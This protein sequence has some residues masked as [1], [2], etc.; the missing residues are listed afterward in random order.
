MAT[1][2]YVNARSA[3]H[4]GGDTV[5]GLKVHLYSA[6]GALLT[7]DTTDADGNAF[8][9]E[10]DADEYEIRISTAWPHNAI[11]GTRKKITVT[12]SDDPQYFDILVETLGLPQAED[13]MLCRCSGVFLGPDG[14]PTPRTLISFTPHQIPHVLA[15]P[16][17]DQPDRA[18]FSHTL[19]VETSSTGYASIDLIRGQLYKVSARP[20]DALSWVVQVPDLPSSSLP[21][22]IFPVP[23]KVEYRADDELLLPVDAP[24]ITINQ[25]GYAYLAITTVYRSGLRVQGLHEVGLLADQWWL[26]STDKSS[27]GLYKFT[28]KSPGVATLTVKA[29]NNKSGYGFRAY[30]EPTFTGTITVTVVDDPDIDNIDPPVGWNG[31]PACPPPLIVDGGEF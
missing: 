28:G 22:V 15:H 7:T 10:R 20:W 3:V 13:S 19:T 18:I 5:S 17:G 30:P 14:R 25:G 21:E 6:A 16:D 11:S 12:E 9:G 23:E 26:L 27:G 4:P 31:E 2:V 24:T 29:A 8:M 1:E